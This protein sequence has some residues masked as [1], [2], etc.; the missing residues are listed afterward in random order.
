MFDAANIE[1]FVSSIK[2]YGLEVKSF[3]DDAR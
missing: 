3:V 1:M 2:N